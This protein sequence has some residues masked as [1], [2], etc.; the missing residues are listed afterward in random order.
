MGKAKLHAA[1][2]ATLRVWTTSPGDYS[3]LGKFLHKQRG[4]PAKLLSYEQQQELFKQFMEVNADDSLIKFKEIVDLI[5]KAVK[6]GFVVPNRVQH[7]SQFFDTANQWLWQLP[8]V[9][10]AWIKQ[11]EEVAPGLLEFSKFYTNLYVRSLISDLQTPKDP[12]LTALQTDI[13]DNQPHEDIAQA[14]KAWGKQVKV[15]NQSEFILRLHEADVG[16]NWQVQCCL[17]LGQDNLVTIS[18]NISAHGTLA[19]GVEGLHNAIKAYPAIDNWEVSSDGFTFSCSLEDVTRFLEIGVPQLRNN[20]IIVMLPKEWTKITPK[21]SVKVETDI[22]PTAYAPMGLEH[23]MRFT[24][25]VAVGD[26]KLTEKE[27]R[28]LVNQKSSLVRLRNQWIQVDAKA[29]VAASKYVSSKGK[30]SELTVGAALNTLS[31]TNKLEIEEPEIVAD[32]WLDELLTGKLNKSIEDVGVP[33]GLKAE[34]RPYQQQGL[35]WLSFMSSLGLGVILADDMGLGKT[36]QLIALVL[37]ERPQK[38][39]PTLVICPMSV[40]GNWEAEIKRF[41]PRL[42]VYI[43]HGTKRLT[44]KQLQN[45]AAKYDIVVST[46]NILTR[47]QATLAKINWNRV[48]LDEAQYV[49]NQNTSQ[50]KAAR[51]LSARH[52]VAL[53][54]TP[55]ENK[56]LELRSIMDFTNPGILGSKKQFQDSYAKPIERHGDDEALAMLR[57]ITGPFILRRSKTDPDIVGDLPEKQELMVRTNLTVEQAGLYKAVVKDMMDRINSASSI[58]RKALVL[59]TLMHLKQVCNHPAHFLGD[60]SGILDS[61]GQHRSGKVER[62]EDILEA[63]LARN[64]RALL[65]TQYTEFGKILQP[66]WEKK[67][68][69]KIP[70]LHGGVQKTQRDKMV[71]SFQRKAKNAPRI[72]LLSLK[73]G[74]TGLN[75]TAANNVIHLDRWWN[76]AVENQATDRAFR[77]GQDKDVQVYK[78]LTV[79]TVEERIEQIIDSKQH[80]ANTV[81][82]TGQGWITELDTDKLRELFALEDRAIGD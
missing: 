16:E 42:K 37:H 78:M 66:Y 54:G 67:F 45:Q 44:A 29:L 52:R 7:E 5:Q 41:T 58:E 36:L 22:T 62:V 51:A 27:M 14:F 55:V 49:K 11:F 38:L 40:V 31:E 34:L 3:F 73:A 12:V 76:P 68:G 81:V 50:S 6:A 61:N 21:L 39:G 1:Y 82:A 70:F 69:V 71:K 25:E 18:E 15:G 23:L 47:D 8:N 33:E 65:F 46:Y 24:W 53:T 13:S 75:L 43:H 64:E 30:K 10:D 79:G 9:V 17:K 4:L 80:L 28:Q 60:N 26:M 63:I 48:V 56:L 74:G 35:N 19:K 59:T 77:I 20:G 2:D 72:M 57:K 32:G